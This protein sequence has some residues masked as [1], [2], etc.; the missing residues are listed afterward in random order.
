[1]V[2]QLSCPWSHRTC[3]ECRTTFDPL[4]PHAGV[5]LYPGLPGTLQLESWASDWAGASPRSSR[6]SS[7]SACP[8]RCG[9]RP[10][11]P[12]SP[13]VHATAIAACSRLCGTTSDRHC[14]DPACGTTKSWCRCSRNTSSAR[15]GVARTP[16]HPNR[17]GSAQPRRPACR[18]C[19][20][21]RL[22]AHDA[23]V[24]RARQRRPGSLGPSTGGRFQDQQFDRP[25]VRARQVWNEA[26]HSS[27]WG[28]TPEDMVRGA[29]VGFAAGATHTSLARGLLL[30][31]GRLVGVGSARLPLST[32]LV[33][34]LRRALGLPRPQWP[35]CSRAAGTSATWPSW[36]PPMT[37][38]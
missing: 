27:G 25:S 12:A 37:W 2:G 31:G 8:C 1:M 17:D 38:Q 34:A 15:V 5:E 14:D 6:T 20:L 4:H 26:F 7:T 33:A 36:T 21:R 11:P 35:R 18:P 23:L 3:T 16:R 30:D 19:A 10:S 9:H 32:A 28:V 13:K 24:S 29:N 22:H